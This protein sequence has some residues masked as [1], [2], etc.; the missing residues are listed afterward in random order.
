MT[1]LEMKDS[2]TAPAE[3]TAA[4]Q[5]LSPASVAGSAV[6]VES[7]GRALAAARK[8][9]GLTQGDVAAQLRLQ[10]RQVRAIEAEDLDALPEGPFVRGFVR[11]Y[12][13][14]VD[15]P[16]EPLL[17]LLAARLKPVEP[18]RADSE[19][20][21]AVSPV[22][23]AAR[24]HAS[25]VTV[26]GGA[27]AMLVIFAVLGWLTMRPG[28]VP[29]NAATP[30]PVPAAVAPVPAAD[31]AVQTPLVVGTPVAAPTAES[32]A[33]APPA[34]PAETPAAAS[35]ALRLSFRDRSWVEITQDDGTVLMSRIN[36]AGVQETVDGKPPYQLV[37]GNASKVDLEFRGERIDLA[38]F[39]SRGDVARLRLE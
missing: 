11:N 32:E 16:A 24:E 37:I 26:V 36:D 22:R 3:P 27:V 9:R 10:L 12:A 17:A 39:A 4:R 29:D 14:L 38:A 18:L 15:A 7:F 25:R 23:L 28:E 21:A 8:A 1:E 5:A 20:S 30:A 35:T 13:K 2:R 34:P 19:G 6:D 31:S 33:V